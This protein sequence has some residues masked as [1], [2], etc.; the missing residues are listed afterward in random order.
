MN[1]KSS[2]KGECADLGSSVFY[3]GNI[4]QT[5]NFNTVS[6]DIIS[7]IHQELMY[8]SYVEVAMDK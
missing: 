4:K 1:N 2:Y 8:G 7:Y 5:D 6:E 3:T